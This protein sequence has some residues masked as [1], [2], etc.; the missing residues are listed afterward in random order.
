MLKEGDK[1]L[2]AHR[3]LFR[4]D[5][6]HYFAG[7]VDAYDAG[8]VKVTGH[9]YVRDPVTGGMIE[10]TE[11]RT[12]ILAL[13]SGTLIVYQLPD[14]TVLDRLE[15]KWEDG[16]VSASDGNGFM[17]NLGEMA[18]R[19]PGEGPRGPPPPS[20]ALRAPP[21]RP[22]AQPAARL[23]PPARPVILGGCGSTRTIAASGHSPRPACSSAAW[24]PGYS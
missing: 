1:V 5:A 20:R 6:A 16:R 7:R 23:P 15:F 21:A 9:S 18:R 10:K 12:K 14:A 17:M 2:V 13:A 8:L 24:P 3:R 4:G 22:T 11:P 19:Q